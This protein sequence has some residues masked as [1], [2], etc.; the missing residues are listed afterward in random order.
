MVDI[1]N[2]EIANCTVLLRWLFS[3]TENA[4]ICKLIYYM[5]CGTNRVQIAYI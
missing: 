1:Q 2:L 3:D 5:Y 4:N